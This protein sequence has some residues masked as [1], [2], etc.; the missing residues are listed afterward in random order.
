M[1]IRKLNAVSGVNKLGRAYTKSAELTF[2]NTLSVLITASFAVSPETSAVTIFQSPN[3]S[4]VNIGTNN[5]LINA[6][7]LFA[8]S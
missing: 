8:L 1:K 5:L 2:N 6:S 4:G 7:R 3:P